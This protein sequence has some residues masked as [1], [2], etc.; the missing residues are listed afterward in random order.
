MKNDLMNA[1]LYEEN[2]KTGKKMT[3]LSVIQNTITFLGAAKY[4]I[5]ETA[6][7]RMQLIVTGHETTIGMF[8]FLFV[9]LLKEPQRLRTAQDEVDQTIVGDG[10]VT[11][12]Q[13]SRLPSLTACL[14]EVL[15]S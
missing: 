13:L 2:T 11:V 6:T 1:M 7:Q 15:R 10:P 14:R 5:S 4:N 12:E 3:H 9:L 8:S